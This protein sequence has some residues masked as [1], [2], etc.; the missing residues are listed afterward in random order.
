MRAIQQAGLKS[1]PAFLLDRQFQVALLAGPLVLLVLVQLFPRY[2]PGQMPAVGFLL[3]V[4]GWQP[5]VEELLFRG[6]LQGWLIRRGWGVLRMAGVSAANGAATLLFVLAHLFQ[7][8]PLHA[9]AVALP[10]LLFGYFRERHGHIWSA[11]FLHAAYNLF[12]FLL[13][14]LLH[15]RA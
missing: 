14:P 9:A 4:A 5:L 3:L 10:S 13:P 6:V 2:L 11:V 12:Y 1:G 7:Q 15:G 8:A